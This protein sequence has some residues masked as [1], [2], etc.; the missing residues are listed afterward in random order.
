MTS[1]NDKVAQSR[2]RRFVM[3]E[4]NESK[5]MREV[6]LYCMSAEVYE[7]AGRY[8]SIT[9]GM[10]NIP[11][12]TAFLAESSGRIVHLALTEDNEKELEYFRS[13]WS[14]SRLRE[15]P[16]RCQQLADDIF[17]SNATDGPRV[18]LLGNCLETRVWKELTHI[19]EGTVVTYKDI[20]ERIDKSDSEKVVANAIVE[21]PVA[22]LIPCHRVVRAHGTLGTYRWGEA[23]K[24]HLLEAE[25]CDLAQLGLAI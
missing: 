16:K 17:D 23:S 8:L 2:N 11:Q 10:V 4:Y 5:V 22:Y 9:Y 12:G 24:R 25:G 14:L 18:L 15:S 3:P 7:S 1:A 13:R 20:A 21:N 19:P 6:H